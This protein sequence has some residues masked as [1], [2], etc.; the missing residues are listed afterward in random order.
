[1]AYDTDFTN[2]Q[3]QGLLRKIQIAIC[4]VAIDVQAEASSTAF[5]AARSAYAL[6]VLANPAGYADVL[7]YGMCA[8][9]AITP[10]SSDAQVKTRA[11]AVWN[12]YAVQT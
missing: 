3:D 10:A 6:L 12:A 9:A 1:M 4:S 8:D 2:A 7:A 11:S 5:H